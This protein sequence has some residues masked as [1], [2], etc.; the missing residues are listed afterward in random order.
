MLRDDGSCERC[1]QEIS[2][3]VDGIRLYRR[4]DVFLDEFFLEVFYVYPFRTCCKSLLLHCRE[5]LFL[6]Y[7]RNECDD[8]ITIVGEPLQYD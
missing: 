7:I 4:E 8:I 5:I 6:P 2:S 1:S 3:F